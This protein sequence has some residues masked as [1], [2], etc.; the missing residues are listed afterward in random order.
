MNM[1]LRRLVTVVVVL[2]ALP[3]VEG[4]SLRQLGWRLPLSPGR[5]IWMALSVAVLLV[6]S[7]VHILHALAWT[8]YA[9][10]LW[11]PALLVGGVLILLKL[12]AGEAPVGKFLPAPLVGGI[13]P[14]QGTHLLL[15]GIVI[16][17]EGLDPCHPSAKFQRRL[18]FPEQRIASL[19]R[20][21]EYRSATPAAA[22]P[23]PPTDAASAL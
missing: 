19:A 4:V 20:F 15:G 8:I 13:F 3:A 9:K 18:T 1:R 21:L 12:S 2:L 10:R 14:E 17:F 22:A 6:L 23:T 7:S 16:P 11:F 5:N